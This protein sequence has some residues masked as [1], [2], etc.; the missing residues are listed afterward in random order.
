M[1]TFYNFTP[2]KKPVNLWFNFLQ[3]EFGY[4]PPVKHHPNFIAKPPKSANFPGDPFLD[5]PP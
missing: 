4:Q 1:T 5:N 2:K 3:R